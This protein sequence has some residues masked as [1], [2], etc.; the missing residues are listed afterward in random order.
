G[1]GGSG[2]SVSSATTAGSSSS[3]GSNPSTAGSGQ[4]SSSAASGVSVAASLG[5]SSGA[6]GSGGEVQVSNA[7]PI[8]TFGDSSMG[9]FAQ[10]VGGGGGTSG[11]SSTNT[12]SGAYSVNFALGAAGGSG[13]QGSE[14][15]VS[16]TAFIQTTGANAIA[17]M[18]QS[19]GGG[20]GN[21]GASSSTSSNS[22]GDASMSMALGSNSGSGNNSGL[23]TVTQ[24]AAVST[25]GTHAT[26]ILAQS[27]GGGGG[28]A[29]SSQSSSTG[30]KASMGLALGGNGGSG[31]V[32]EEV[33]VFAISSIGTQGD[34]ASAVLAQSVGGGGG[35]AASAS[36]TS[37]NGGDVNATLSIGGSSAGGGDGGTVFVSTYYVDYNT[38]TG[39][40]LTVPQN[41]KISTVG[42]LS[43]A[44]VAQSIGGGGGNG[45]SS[46]SSFNSSS[47]NSNTTS[48]G[49]ALG[50]T[51]A[52]GGD[53]EQ[54]TLNSGLAVSTSGIGSHAL[55]AQSVGG[56]GGSGGSASTTPAGGTSTFNL[57]LGATGGSGGSAGAVTVTSYSNLTTSGDNAA[58]LIAQSVG[59]G[60]G[61]GG[62]SNNNSFGPA[63]SVV[64]H[65][66]GAAGGSAGLAGSVQ[67]NAQ[68]SILTSGANAPAVVAQ[69]VSGG[70]G[71]SQSTLSQSTSTQ[72]SLTLGGTASVSTTASTS[73]NVQVS[74]SA[75]ITTNGANS[76]GVIAQSVGAGGGIALSTI[77][78]GSVTFESSRLGSQSGSVGNAL[79][80]TVNQSGTV[81]TAGA[82][83]IGVLAQSVGGGGGYAALVNQSSATVSNAGFMTIGS[84]GSSSGD[85]GDVTVTIGGAVTTTG[86]S[87]VGVFAQS[88]GGGGGA[89]TSVGSGQLTPGF[90]AGD[91]DGGNVT[92]NINAP[93][94]VSGTGSVGVLAQSVGGGGGLLRT[95]GNFVVGSGQ[96]SGSAGIVAINVNSSVM[97]TGGTAIYAGSVKGDNDP[98]IY[99]APGALVSS[100]GGTAIVF[101]GQ[102][103]QLLN[104][105]SVLVADPVNDLVLDIRQG[106]QTT[107]MNYGLLT[108]QIVNRS[109]LTFMNA[110][111]GTMGAGSALNNF[112]TLLVGRRG[113]ADTLELPAALRN[114]AIGTMVFFVD[115]QNNAQT[116]DQIRVRDSATIDGTIAVNVASLLPV[117]YPF[118]TAASVKSNAQI[119]DTLLFDWD[120]RVQGNTLFGVVQADFTPEGRRLT[121]L[122][123]SNADYLQRIWDAGGANM[124]PVFGYLHQ[125]GIDEHA[126]YQNIVQQ[127]A[128]GVLNSQAIEF[129]TMFSTSLTDS[130]SCPLMTGEG[131]RLN[132]TNC[133]WGKLT[134]SIAD[135]SANDSN[136]G[137]H[138]TASGIRLG[139]QKRIDEQ[140]TAGF[141]VGYGNNYLTSTRFTSS[142]QFFNASV[143]LQK[144]VEAWT[145]G[146]SIGM[147][148]GWLK[149]NRSLSLP[150][151]SPA[152]PLS[153]L[154]TSNSGMTMLGLKLR[155]AYTQAQGHYYIKPYVDVD[156][157]Y[158]DLSGFSES[159]GLL[160]LKAQS[161]RQYNIAVTPMLEF[162]TELS[163][164]QK[165][166]IKGYVSIGASFLPSNQITTQ[167]SLAN[168]STNV[169]TY[170]VT[171]DGP[172]VLGRL[173]I[174]L[175][176]FDSD[177]LEFRVQYG[178][179]AGQGYLS[180]NLSANLRY[181]F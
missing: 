151:G 2:G 110:P 132:Q 174:G 9:V 167:M 57:A 116:S 10:S 152:Q 17:I 26:G 173:N 19:V 4:T 59:G 31:G 43:P 103:N 14:V 144:K 15:N 1:G 120:A 166:Q 157:T 99:I 107:V 159:G 102:V 149:N 40:A 30:G 93:V 39:A 36:S 89:F 33:E 119:Q 181:R 177:D 60:G 74:S 5:G 49:L 34:H 12:N 64:S 62:V 23:V 106:G 91:G 86:T 54:V 22:G 161:G 80:V 78:A 37:G 41:Q 121:G 16:S 108:G 133:T 97:V 7:V 122:Q 180:Q 131:L 155:A 92:V 98:Y 100:A 58:G 61:V 13:G 24:S 84:T 47:Q 153:G 32:G 8:Y 114:G 50:G 72:Y 134:G 113:V 170:G 143:S 79:P 115:A 85:G 35:N 90:S 176:V 52:T 48:V 69:S 65:L 83:A 21:A 175:Q 130:L 162:G 81:N 169:G 164:D 171:T 104:Y 87:S 111:G 129:K 117:N 148:Q 178:L 56:G 44:I 123:G 127:I 154:Y 101:D 168:L 70:G 163:T 63:S 124:A 135:Q 141:S 96:G 66:L 67:V 77:E 156:L 55:F 27:I 76:I 3:G 82:G 18:A 142:G 94:T 147:A 11:A 6:G 140:W 136:S 45:G 109:E 138:V 118:I 28:N 125:L 146:G 150:S 126:Q 112:G 145:F 73:S 128:G 29:T 172:K 95:E 51:S 179:Q 42:D 160:A 165:R 88:V 53:G 139:S 25:Q 75:T 20:G 158:S 71:L 105:G 68:S 137:Y 46:V 38:Q